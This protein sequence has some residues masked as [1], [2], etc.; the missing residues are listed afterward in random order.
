MFVVPTISFRLL[1]GLLI[2]RHSRRQLV[3]ADPSAEWIARQ[4]TEACGWCEP[5]RYIIR[6][7]DGAYGGAFIRRLRAMGIRDRRDCLDHVVIFGEQ[8]LRHV[9]SSY[10]QYY[11]EVRTHLSLTKDAPIP[12]E[13]KRVGRVLG[14]PI[15]GGLRIGMSESEISDKD[16]SDSLRDLSTPQG[17][18][19]IFAPHTLDHE[20]TGFFYGY[21]IHNDDNDQAKRQYA[22][23]LVPAGHVVNDHAASGRFRFTLD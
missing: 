22:V 18:L 5:P 17:T 21:L 19:A 8:H 4:L 12:R 10:L 14:Q 3:T 15:L 13:A 6:D 9:L 11:S 7:R 20:G 23:Y 2:L 1:Y 16:R